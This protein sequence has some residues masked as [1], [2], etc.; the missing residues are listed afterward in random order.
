M[1]MLTRLSLFVA[2]VMTVGLAA[3]TACVVWA[4]APMGPVEPPQAEAAARPN[5]PAASDR[6]DLVTGPLRARVH[7]VVVDEAGKPIPGI[8]VRVENYDDRQS[9]GVTDSNGDFRVRDPKP[10]AQ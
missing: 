6:A 10:L 5:D 1:M 2:S 3:L 9:R 4:S 7:G 8:E